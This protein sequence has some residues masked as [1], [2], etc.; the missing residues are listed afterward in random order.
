MILLKI[1]LENCIEI[2]SVDGDTNSQLEQQPT[3]NPFDDH[4]IHFSWIY[5]FSCPF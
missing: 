4:K 5:Q 3:K 1:Y 2:I